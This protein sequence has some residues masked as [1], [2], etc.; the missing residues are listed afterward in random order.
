VVSWL[1]LSAAQRLG[2][3]VVLWFCGFVVL[4]FCGFVVLW[5][6]FSGGCPRKPAK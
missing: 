4:W 3:F 2:G 5:E 1:S 6:A